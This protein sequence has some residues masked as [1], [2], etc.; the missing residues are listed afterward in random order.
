MVICLAKLVYLFE[1][2]QIMNLSWTTLV[3]SSTGN[4]PCVHDT[5]WIVCFCY[6]P[7][8]QWNGIERKILWSKYKKIHTA[9]MALST[10]QWRGTARIPLPESILYTKG[11][12]ANGQASEEFT[13]PFCFKAFIK[14]N[15]FLH[16]C[17]ISAVF[18]KSIHIYP[19][20]LGGNSAPFKSQEKV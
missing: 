4:Q 19:N 10:K 2:K 9:F 15:I 16:T 11:N 8:K 3:W 20:L 5:F 17:G 18:Q 12:S 6:V 13:T 1:L 7:P 14:T